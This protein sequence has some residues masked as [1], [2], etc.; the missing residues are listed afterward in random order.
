MRTG[1]VELEVV[2]L[3]VGMAKI[4]LF[5]YECCVPCEILLR[6]CFD[7]IPRRLRRQRHRILVC[8]PW[9]GVVSCVIEQAAPVGSAS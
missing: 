2:F 8:S 5:L 9:L 3:E 4:A 6:G 1:V 7:Y